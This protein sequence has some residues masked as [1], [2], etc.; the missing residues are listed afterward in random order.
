M[1]LELFKHEISNK[2]DTSLSLASFCS[3]WEK[4]HNNNMFPCINEGNR[5]KQECEDYQDRLLILLLRKG[6]N[7]N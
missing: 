1:R 6:G 5:M 2:I 4:N 7:F 3:T